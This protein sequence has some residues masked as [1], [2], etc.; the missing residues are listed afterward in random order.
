M[1]AM[2]V[3][4]RMTIINM[5][6]QRVDFAHGSMS[7]MKGG[8]VSPSSQLPEPY[9]SEYARAVAGRRVDY[10]LFSYRTPIAWKLDDGT[11]VVPEVS[12]SV[13]TSVHQAVAREALA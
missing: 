8:D 1:G 11:T 2:G 3:K 5:T 9:A 6:S 10:S 7:G 12:Y 13:T 4:S